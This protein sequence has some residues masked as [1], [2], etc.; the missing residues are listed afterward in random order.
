MRRVQRHR[1]AVALVRSAAASAPR[2]AGTQAVA[3]GLSGYLVVMNVE[4]L[5]VLLAGSVAVN[6]VLL[7]F[8][9]RAAQGP[10]RAKPTSR[11]RRCGYDIRASFGGACP[12]CGEPATPPRHGERAITL[13]SFCSKSSHQTGP[14]VE[15]PG[16]AYICAPCVELCHTILQQNRAAAAQAASRK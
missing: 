7:L 4:L 16:D 15:G 12:E 10:P 1:Y 3:P 14:Q 8:I 13:C 6:A 2:L 9:G 5:I 11:C